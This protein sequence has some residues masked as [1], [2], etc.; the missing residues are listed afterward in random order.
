MTSVD[1]PEDT[2]YAPDRLSHY[3]GSMGIRIRKA[4]RDCN[5]ELFWHL[6][7]LLVVKIASDGIFSTS[8]TESTYKAAQDLYIRLFGRVLYNRESIEGMVARIGKQK[9]VS[10]SDGT[11]FLEAILKNLYGI[12]IIVTSNLP[13]YKNHT[14]VRLLRSADVLRSFRKRI[15]LNISC[16]GPIFINSE[17]CKNNIVIN[18]GMC[19]Y[20][21]SMVA[22]D[23]VY[24]CD[25]TSTML[26]FFKGQTESRIV[27]FKRSE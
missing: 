7:E 3:V 6:Y 2:K 16:D 24:K 17:F 11:A 9:V 15:L 1:Y 22:S 27:F 19:E 21:M 23:K 8:C 5:I 13:L 18:I 20:E 12:N 4:L 10:I 14:H 25:H 26:P